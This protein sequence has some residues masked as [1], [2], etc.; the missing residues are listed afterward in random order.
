VSDAQA[1]ES[2]DPEPVTRRF[3]G[4]IAVIVIALGVVALDQGTKLWALSTMSVGQRTPIIPDVLEWV[5]AKNSG[6]A[7]SLLSGA[8]WV[9]TIISTAVV[10]LILFSL[11]RVQSPVWAIV[12]G[13]VLGGASGNLI[14]RLFREPGF[15]LGH[16]I[17]FIYT[18]W[19]VPAIY[20]VA[21]MGVV[22]GMFLFLLLTIL[23]VQADGKRARPDKKVKGDAVDE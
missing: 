12:V 10:V 18:P 5:L 13:L 8:T 20:N 2:V 4:W 6:A 9:F 23:G 14:D 16:V 22:I 15:G 19:I 1:P 17:D 3:R 11:R 7:F 21:D